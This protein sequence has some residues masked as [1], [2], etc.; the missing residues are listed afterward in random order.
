M[1]YAVKLGVSVAVGLVGFSMIMVRSSIGMIIVGFIVVSIAVIFGSY[2]SA[3]LRQP[4]N[5]MSPEIEELLNRAQDKNN[6]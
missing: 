6:K 1:S 2:F 4:K 5:S 3:K